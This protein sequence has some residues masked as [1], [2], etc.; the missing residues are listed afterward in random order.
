MC[1]YIIL[2]PTLHTWQ[3]KHAH[4]LGRGVN[5]TILAGESFVLIKVTIQCRLE[6]L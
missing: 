3:M 6:N 1:S 5:L 2:L 4:P